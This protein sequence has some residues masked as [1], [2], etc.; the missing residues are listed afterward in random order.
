MKRNT[1]GGY[2][3]LEYSNKRN[4]FGIK[5]KAL[6]FHRFSHTQFNKIQESGILVFKWV[7]CWKKCFKKLLEVVSENENMGDINF[8]TV[9]VFL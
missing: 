9:Q 7:G 1:P 6:F 3:I 2:Y 8:F 4:L 5:Y